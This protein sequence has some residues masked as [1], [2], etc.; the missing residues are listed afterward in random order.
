MPLHIEVLYNDNQTAA[1][2]AVASLLG[3]LALATLAAKAVLERQSLPAG[4]GS[5][6]VELNGVAKRFAK[7]EVL[8]SVD[9]GI[10]NG[11][12]LALV[13][14]SGSGKTALLRIIAGLDRPSAERILRDGRD[15]TAL[16]SV[17]RG[18]GLSFSITPSSVI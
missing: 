18:S 13:G 17:E 10:E 16:S 2:F 9:L 14:P 8:A 3:L 5:M 4:V 7:T 1:A 6:R 15:A 12:L 11:E